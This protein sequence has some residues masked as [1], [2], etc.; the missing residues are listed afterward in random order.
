MTS[1]GGERIGDLGSQR[2]AVLGW[3]PTA[4]IQELGEGAAL[5]EI[6]RDCNAV[7]VGHQLDDREDMGMTESGETGQL[8][9]EALDHALLTTPRHPLERD[10]ALTSSRTR[11]VHHADRAPADHLV[12]LIAIQ[13][14]HV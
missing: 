7:L 13:P 4:P 5:R 2:R 6:H 9:S 12:D 14:S 11:P 10:H 3:Q 1:S 8:R